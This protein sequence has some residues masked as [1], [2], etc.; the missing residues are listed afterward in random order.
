MVDKYK[1]NPITEKMRCGKCGGF[2][3]T[4]CNVLI[5]FEFD[6]G[7]RE[8]IPV[9]LKIECYTKDGIQYAWYDTRNNIRVT[10][11]IDKRVKA[12]MYNRLPKP[13]EGE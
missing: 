2:P 1:W 6:Y 13:Y 5:T 11:K 10:S 12:W 9:Q 7:K 8:V 4:D 3:T